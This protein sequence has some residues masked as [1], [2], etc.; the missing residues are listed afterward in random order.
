ML[1][2]GF[3][4]REATRE[5]PPTEFVAVLQK[6]A[7]TPAFVASINLDTRELTVRPLAAA[8]ATRQIL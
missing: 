3:I 5:A 2:V 1:A 6:S 4:V 7:E 8:A